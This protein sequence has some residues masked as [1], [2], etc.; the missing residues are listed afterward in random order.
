MFLQI[1]K[2]YFSQR[3]NEAEQHVKLTL[4]LKEVRCKTLKFH[5]FRTP[6]QESQLNH[7]STD[8]ELRENI[9]KSS[10]NV[11]GSNKYFRICTSLFGGF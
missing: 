1:I 11:S 6:S 10:S 7:S 5:E 4:Y 3:I 9:L 2:S 8:V